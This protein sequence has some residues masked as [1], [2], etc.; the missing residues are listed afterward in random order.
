MAPLNLIAVNYTAK[1]GSLTLSAPCKTDIVGART[2]GPQ[3]QFNPPIL[4]VAMPAASFQRAR[5]T[6][7]G[8]SG[9]PFDFDQAGLLFLRPHTALP[10]PSASEPGNAETKPSFAKIALETF[11]QKTFCT[12]SASNQVDTEWSL[13]PGP[14]TTSPSEKTEVT[15]EIAKMG[16]ML[17]AFVMEGTGETAT[18]TLFRVVSWAFRD[19]KESEPDI[20]VG[21]YASRPTTKNETT[22]ALEVEFRDFEIE[23]TEGIIKF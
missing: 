10:E 4:K 5:V 2:T 13:W 23:T 8:P 20:W 14:P 11:E 17:L 3:F 7:V 6:V 22:E 19:V 16:P 12:V 15:F 18:R 21:L 9:F 1:P